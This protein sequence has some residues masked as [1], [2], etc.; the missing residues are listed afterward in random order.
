MK[1]L[2]TNQAD[3]MEKVKDLEA[4]DTCQNAKSAQ[5]N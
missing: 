4:T 5:E 2:I 1:E 3:V